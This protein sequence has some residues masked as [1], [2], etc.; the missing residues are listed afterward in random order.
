MS[1]EIRPIKQSE[2]GEFNR[3]V[4]TVFAAGPNMN[5]TMPSEWTLC[6]F[7][8]GTMTTSYAYWPVTLLL[9][10][11]PVPVAGI[12]MVGTLPFYRRKNYLRQVT[13]RSFELLHEQGKRPVSALFASRTAIYQRYGYAVVTSRDSYQIDPRDIQLLHAPEGGGVMHEAGDAGDE[14]LLDLYHR[15]IT[16]RNGYLRREGDYF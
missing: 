12:T 8:D 4:Q 16:G 1:F 14:L 11:A 9:N 15:F 2:L 10:G 5:V 3:I 13:K 7:E 6:G